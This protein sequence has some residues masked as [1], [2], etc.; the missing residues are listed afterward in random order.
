MSTYQLLRMDHTY[1]N[2]W[3]QLAQ[4]TSANHIQND[5][6]ANTLF[7]QNTIL[8]IQECIVQV[9]VICDTKKLKD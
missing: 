4:Q 6:K 9:M 5:V 8:K 2:C 1:I 3:K 7:S